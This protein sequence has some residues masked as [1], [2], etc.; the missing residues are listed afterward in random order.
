LWSADEDLSLQPYAL[1]EILEGDLAPLALDLAAAGVTDPAELPWLDE[2]PAAAFSQARELLRELEALDDSGR[3]TPHGESMSRF[4]M[5]PRLAHMLIRGAEMG[6]GTPACELAALLGERD[7]LRA[8][9]DTVGTDVRS[10]IDALHKPREFPGVD[11]GVLRRVSEQARRWRSRL[12]RGNERAEAASTGQLLALAYPDRVARRRPGAVPRF[13]LRNGTGAT[14]PEGDPLSQEAFLVIAESDG[15]A[16]EARAWLT[17][18]LSLA[19]IEEDFGDQILHVET[20]EWDDEHG[21][22]A[23]WERRLG[24]LVLSRSTLRDPDPAL[25]AASVADGIRRRGLDVLPWTAGARRLRER[26]AF[27]H[28][29]DPSWPDMSGESLTASLLEQLH[30]GLGQVRAGSALRKVDVSS[31]L[32]GMLDWDQ[33]RR[34]DQLAP[35]HFEAPTGS[36]IPIDY[37]DPRSPTASVRLQELFG[38]RDTP[39]VLGGR[40]ALTLQ[41]LSPAQRP[42]QVTRDLAGFWRS[43]YFDV[44][45]DLRSRYPKHPWPDDPMSAPPTRRAKPRK[46]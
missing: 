1:P 21:V 38:T 25:V 24:A 9:R 30:G 40:V 3:I 33:R 26:I 36:R 44:R 32:L 42:V 31:A 17:A 18:P 43:S 4:G 46:G 45:K 23:F 20:A 37:S 5:H 28:A 27:L 22:R 35:T 34:L 15:R 39:T 12:P 10:R 14:L 7:P 16:P 2:P 29:H 11:Q 13:H 19:D 8:M 6:A 41:L